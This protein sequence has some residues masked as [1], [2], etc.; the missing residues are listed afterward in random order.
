MQQLKSAFGY[1]SGGWLGLDDLRRFRAQPFAFLQGLAEEQGGIATFRFGPVADVYLVTD[2][3]YIREILVK[4]WART[5]KWERMTLASSRVTTFNIVFLEGEVWKSQRRL[6]TPA[7][8]TE[9]VRQYLSLIE[10]HAEGL[11]ATWQS[12]QSHDIRHAM[13]SVTMSIIGEI[14]FD[15]E[16]IEQVATPLST[17][18]DTLLAQFVREAASFIVLPAWLPTANHKRARHAKQIIITY[19]NEMIAQR[20]AQGMDRGDVLSA[21]ISAR[22]AETGQMLTDEQIRD[23]L[24]SLFVAGHETTAMWLTWTLYLLATHPEIQAALRTEINAMPAEPGTSGRNEGPATLLDQVLKEALRLYPPAW[25]LFLRRAVEDIHLDDRMIPRDGVI[26]I[27]PYIQHRLPQYWPDPDRFDPS[28][29]TGDWR[30]RIPAY[31]YMP[32]GGG[33]RVCLGANL[34]EL[35]TSIILRVILSRYTISL[36]EPEQPVYPDGGFTLRPYPGLILHTD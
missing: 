12:G 30:A 7:F 17:A 16:D 15:I 19:L 6:L 3:E 8:H 22:D 20:R 27:S 29:F 33:P 21:L 35:E 10:K 36:A 18:I 26:Y 24:Y 23:E 34:A 4:Q 9:R 32:F 5:I 31:A 28:R 2:P 25:S 13:A 14:L 1:K 11:L